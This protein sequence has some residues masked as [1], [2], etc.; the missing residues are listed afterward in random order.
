MS[1]Q[2]NANVQMVVW[3]W[4]YINAT[5]YKMFV[6]F[7][8][9]T[10]KLGLMFRPFTKPHYPIKTLSIRLCS[11]IKPKHIYLPNRAGCKA[12][13]I[14]VYTLSASSLSFRLYPT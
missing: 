1:G 10:L 12:R 14:I 13:V 11:Q 8:K 6:N 5:K 2:L 7:I 9:T 4:L 3:S